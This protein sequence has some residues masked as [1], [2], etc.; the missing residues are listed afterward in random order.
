[1]HWILAPN[2]VIARNHPLV[3]AR[4]HPLVI[5][6]NHPL[7]IARNGMTKQSISPYKIAA[8]L[9]A[10][11][12]FKAA[13]LAMT[14]PPSLSEETVQHLSGIDASRVVGES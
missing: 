2:P 5:A 13:L 6:R 12:G 1:M 11:T 10:M 8:S 7:V 9:L 4:N 14:V 3:I